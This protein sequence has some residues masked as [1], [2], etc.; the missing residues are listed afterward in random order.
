M[1]TYSNF[2]AVN[3]PTKLPY[4]NYLTCSHWTMPVGGLDVPPMFQRWPE[5]ERRKKS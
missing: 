1:T 5:F 4:F 3:R 2:L